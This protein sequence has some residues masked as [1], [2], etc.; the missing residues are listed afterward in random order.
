[1]A[2]CGLCGLANPD[3]AS[4]VGFFL[5]VIGARVVHPSKIDDHSVWLKGVNSAY[6]AELPPSGGWR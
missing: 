1:M 2:T 6:L 3:G 5:G 4:L